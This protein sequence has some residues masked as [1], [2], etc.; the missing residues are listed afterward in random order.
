MV[1]Y[2]SDNNYISMDI[3]NNTLAGIYGNKKHTIISLLSGQE[4]FEGDVVLDSISLKGN[5]DEYLEHIAVLTKDS[6]VNTELSV[7]DFL[8]FFGTMSNAFTEDY[9]E[10]KIAMLK[11]FGLFSKINTGINYLKEI[12]RKKV[13]FMS[14]LLKERTLIVMDAFLE[15]FHKSELN[16]IL[17][18]LRKY[19]N[20][21]RIV[22][23]SSEDYQLLESFS[24]TIY[25]F[26]S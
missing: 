5:Y 1:E 8:D 17:K 22:L 19:A 7:N 23:I 3:K 24:E 26:N 11:E 10:R 16:K 4:S 13:K 2:P 9:E 12:D 6:M 15:S 14:L 18:F 20:G 25:I 21:E